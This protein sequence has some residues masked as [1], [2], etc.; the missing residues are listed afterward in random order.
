[1]RNNSIFIGFISV[2]CL[3]VIQPIWASK[4]KQPLT[5]KYDLYAGGIH[6][7]NAS[8]QFEGTS[9]SYTTA[10]NAEIQGFLKHIIPWKGSLITTGNL[11]FHPNFHFIPQDHI[12]LSLWPDETKR[13]EMSYDPQGNLL[14][15]HTYFDEDGDKYDYPDDITSAIPRNA[16]DLV[17]AT[18]T[19]LHNAQNGKPCDERIPVFDGKRRF[20]L[21][22]TPVGKETLE[23]NRYSMFAGDA[24]KCTVELDMK[25]ERDRRKNEFFKAQENSKKK[26]QLPTIWMGKPKMDSTLLVPVKMAVH[27]DYGSLVLHLTDISGNANNLQ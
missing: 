15:S 14:G 25:N 6:A 11:G 19:W 21:V 3:L 9:S 23:V 22:L 12:R 13:T 17:S 8:I 2:F 7:M 4:N 24:Y 26:G 18:I 16:M 5:L 27:S 20:D 10:F 1:M